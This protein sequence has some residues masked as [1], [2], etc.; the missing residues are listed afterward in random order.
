MDRRPLQN[1]LLALFAGLAALTSIA[2]FTGCPSADPNNPELLQTIQEYTQQYSQEYVD[3][4]AV[5]IA[6]TTTVVG[7]QG[8][9][10][11]PGPASAI[12]SVLAGTGLA[13]GGQ[14]GSVTLSIAPAGVALDRIS[15][16]GAAANQ[17]IKFVNGQV[18]WAPDATGS[19]GSSPITGVLP[20]TGLTGGGQ[21]GDVTL[22]IA[23]AG[24]GLDRINTTGAAT[25]QVLK[26]V[27][28]ALTWAEDAGGGSVSITAGSGIICS[29]GTIT[30]A[31][32]VSLDTSWLDAH[33]DPR[34]L[35][36]SATIAPSK[37]SPQ[38]SGSTL[39]A[40]MLDGQHGAYYQN[41][42]NLTTGTLSDL[43]LSS[44]V[45]L[46]GS[47]QTISGAKTFTNASN[48]FTGSGANLT[49]LS[50]SNIAVGTLSLARLPSSGGSG[51]YLRSDGS[52]PYW[53]TISGSGSQWTTSGSN[54]Y[55]SNGNV[56]VGTSSPVY[57]LDVTSSSGRNVNAANS[58]DTG[59]AGYFSASGNDGTG[60]YGEASGTGAP[61]GLWGRSYSAAGVGV[62]GANH[63]TTGTA[64]GVLGRSYSSSGRGVYG[65][66]SNTAGIAY[67]VYGK[68]GIANGA[69]YA[70][71]AEG[72]MA[73]SGL[74]PFRI[75]HPDDPA[76]KYLL[77]YAS[78]SPEVIN[79]YRGTVVLDGAG[80]AKIELPYYF[81][82]INKN[83]SYQLTAIGRPMPM[84]HVTDEISED[85]LAEGA[86][87]APGR[88]A[89]LCSFRITGGAPGAKV[90]WRVEAIRNDRWVQ[91]RGAPVEVEKQGIE[92][93]TYQHPELYGQSPEKSLSYLAERGE[94]QTGT[95]LYDS[96]SR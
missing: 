9:K 75:D 3:Q 45:D 13:G 35:G 31:G 33:C 59:Y 52:T 5:K 43:R 87:A 42:G 69:G 17:V 41:A 65:W 57:P 40:D 29:P 67:G 25:N 64:W 58:S 86:Q 18:A 85:A 6:P 61:Y 56:G 51:Y 12:T 95:D 96:R 38:G 28:G 94:T 66:A 55:Y 4:L 11:D 76:N 34:Y 48:S 26:Y 8:P 47:T 83:P 88:A 24:V 79:F 16:S 78:E 82:K 71:Y 30:G 39:D 62:V 74:K 1:R 77:H 54:I 23:P 32:S 20:G 72:N 44:N 63:S 50:A 91:Q 36:A 49:G 46:L 15:P 90:C 10:G 53:S 81:A 19:D 2:T 84:L 89:P 37:I 70:V 7:P 73:A 14:S 22:S 27:N 68:G 80:E 92:K 21:S 93:G 60:V